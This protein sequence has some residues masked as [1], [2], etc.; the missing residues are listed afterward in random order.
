MH[1]DYKP[2]TEYSF[3]THK[4][5]GKCS[6]RWNLHVNFKLVLSSFFCKCRRI[7]LWKCCWINANRQLCQWHFPCSAQFNVLMYIQQYKFFKNFQSKRIVTPNTLHC[8]QVALR[9][10]ALI[11]NSMALH[12][13]ENINNGFTAHCVRLISIKRKTPLWLHIIFI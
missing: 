6:C 9:P 13:Y 1:T 5:N 12:Q 2:Y 8:K 3:R 11:V 7:Q 10:F 4:Q